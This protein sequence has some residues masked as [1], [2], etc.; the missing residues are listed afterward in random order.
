MATEAG[1]AVSSDGCKSQPSVELCNER[2]N[3]P[4]CK[5]SEP[6]DQGIP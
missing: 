6:M 2:D 5:Q 3:E 1:A 4:H